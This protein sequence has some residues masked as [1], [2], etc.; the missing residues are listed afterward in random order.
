MNQ[1]LNLDGK[2]K[3]FLE[4]GISISKFFLDNQESKDVYEEIGEIPVY[5]EIEKHTNVKYELNKETNK[6]EIDRV[7]PYPYFYPYSYG[8]ITNTRADD[9]D[10]LD[11][12][13]LSKNLYPRDIIVK[14]HMIG[15]LIMEDE[16]GMDHKIFCVPV[17]ELEEFCCLSKTK[18]CEMFEDIMWF[19]SNY[20]SKEK[21]KWS[22]VHGIVNYEVANDIY[23]KSLL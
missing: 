14:T 5:I 21:K 23:Q 8:F 18:L 3:D 13:I 2:E 17:N 12:L 20:K 6:L 10:E 7:L 1:S 15:A 9:G 11:A 19:F 4:R 22:K 16:K